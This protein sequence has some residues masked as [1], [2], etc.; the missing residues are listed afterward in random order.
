MRVLVAED[1]PLAAMVIE[2]ALIE[3]GH[4]VML[5]PDGAAALDLARHRVFDILLTD[6]AM[7]RLTGFELI[8]RLRADHPRL[9]VVVMTGFLPPGSG[10]VLFAD[11]EGPLVVLHKPFDIAQLLAAMQ[12]V[13]P[14]AEAED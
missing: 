1:E 13:A 3:R 8:S 12:R 9:P 2:E 6:L 7:P 5:A 10:Q 14:P 11:A 4:E